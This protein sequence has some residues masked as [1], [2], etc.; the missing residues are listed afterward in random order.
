MNDQLSGQL[1]D[2]QSGWKIPAYARGL[3]WLE[4][5]SGAVKAEG[6]Q[7]LF[8]LAAPAQVL[9]LRWGGAQGP[10][11]AQLPWRVDSLEWDGSVRVGGY[12]DAMHI[13][14]LDDLPAPVTILQV[15]GQPLKPG[16]SAFATRASRKQV[17]YAVPSFFDG[18]ADEVDESITTWMALEDSAAL[19]LAQDALVS[20]L[21]VYL[22]G[23]L[24]EQDAGWHE[25]FALPVALEA[26]TLFAP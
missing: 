6:A 21:G 16:I 17:P 1:V 19:T 7:G 18:L 3:L 2:P 8:T 22:F 15:G 14:E 20:K 23:R 24:A 26:M 5:E 9:T 11:L 25:H 12:V 4:G 13:T 10:A